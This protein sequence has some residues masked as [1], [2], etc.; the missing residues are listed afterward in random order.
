MARQYG[1]E[2][3]DLL[4]ALEL[5]ARAGPLR[6]GEFVERLLAATGCSERAAKD[7]NRILRR[8]GFVEVVPRSGDRRARLYELS[9]RGR[10]L[11]ADPHGWIVLRV[12]RKLFTS[13]PS[14]AG[15]RF[16][17]QDEKGGREAELAR[18]ERFLLVGAAESDEDDEGPHARATEERR[19]APS[20][21]ARAWALGASRE[22]EAELTMLAGAAAMLIGLVTLTPSDL[23][24]AMTLQETFAQ[25]ARLTELRKAWREREAFLQAVRALVPEAT[26]GAILAE[27]TEASPPRLPRGEI[28]RA[29]SPPA[30]LP[31]DAWLAVALVPA[32]SPR[33]GARPAGGEE[34]TL[35]PL[36]AEGLELLSATKTIVEPREAFAA[37]AFLHELDA[38]RASAL[39]A[40]L[41]RE[42]DA[43]IGAVKNHLPQELWSVLLE[44]FERRLAA[45]A[46]SSGNGGRGRDDRASADGRPDATQARAAA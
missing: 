33:P 6:F 3:I 36:L 37:A 13:C 35:A 22:V 24:T 15:A 38:K 8:G 32:S 29:A 43:L 7:A 4:Q 10:A 27:A 45:D 40:E 2:K 14:R 28:G 44:E 21:A 5:L 34:G 23:L 16:Q 11:L 25:D 1:H 42:L 46:P 26:W 17:R 31:L 12:A 39:L 9:E 41:G 19:G 20:P 18:V 30:P